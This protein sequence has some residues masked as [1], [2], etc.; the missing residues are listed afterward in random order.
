MKVLDLVVPDL[1]PT[2]VVVEKVEVGG[3]NALGVEDPQPRQRARRELEQ[4]RVRV[5]ERRDD[6][7]HPLRPRE[8]LKRTHSERESH[9]QPRALGH[10]RK[11]QAADSTGNCA[12][13]A[14][15]TCE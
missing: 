2:P 3:C 5:R 6:L 15:C 7:L 9:G 11:A 10:K 8:R 13:V 4:E 12:T 1:G 14:E